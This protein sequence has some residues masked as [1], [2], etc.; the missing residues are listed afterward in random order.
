MTTL[1]TGRLRD[2]ARERF[3]DT[4]LGHGIDHL[5]RVEA[6][7][8]RFLP[9]DGSPEITSAVALLHDAD[10]YKLHPENTDLSGMPLATEILESAGIP[11]GD[12]DY[13]KGC[14]R[15][16]GYSKRLGGI[17][18]TV[19]EAMAVSDADMCDI[20]GVDGFMRLAAWQRGDTSMLFDPEKWPNLHKSQEQYK[21]SRGPTIIQHMFEK[22]LKLPSMMLTEEGA[23][24][25]WQRWTFSVALLREL[26]RERSEPRW[27]EYL[28]KY[29][30][31]L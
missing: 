9:E 1:Q 10:D 12:A 25:A 17:M 24:E 20:M 8:L 29:L 28:R 31:A 15:T 18:P 2:I 4:G 7:A 16:I 11:E 27:D 21:N 19:P 23:A 3:A 6:M 30:E 26:F 5:L 13:I 22:V 14:I